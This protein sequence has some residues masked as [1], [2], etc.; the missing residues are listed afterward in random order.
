VTLICGLTRYP[1]RRFAVA[2]AVAAVVWASY[3]FLAGRIGGKA[4]EHQPLVGFAVAFGGALALS[5]LVEVIRRVIAWRR[6][7]PPEA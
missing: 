6:K 4:F 7:G 2:T 5:A 1:W 3:A